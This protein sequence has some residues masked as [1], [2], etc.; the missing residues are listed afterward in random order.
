MRVPIDKVG[1]VGMIVDKQSY[2]LPPEAWSSLRNVRCID[3]ALWSTYGHAAIMGVPRVSPYFLLPTLD[4]SDSVLWAYLGT[5]KAW[6]T[7][8]TTHQDITRV[9]GGDYTG[10]NANLW[11]GGNF[12]GITIL[13]NGINNPQAWI[14]PALATPLVDL[15]NWPAST[16]ARVVR[17]LGRF[18]VALDVTQSSVRRSQLVKWSHEA[19]IG[20]VPS[21]WD[22]ADATKK[23]GEWPLLETEG[24]CIDL[25][26]LGGDGI[27]YKSDSIHRMSRIAGRFVFGFKQIF[28]DLGSGILA[29][30]CAAEWKGRHVVA[31]TEDVIV[32]DG[33]QYESLLDDSMYRWYQGRVDQANAFRSFVAVNGGEN[34][35][36]VCLPE[37][38]N[39]Y[40]NIALILNMKDGTKTIR[41]LPSVAHIHSGRPPGASQTFDA[42][43]IP[44]DSM[45][46]TFGQS[47][48]NAAR[49]RMVAAVPFAE[50]NQI[51][52]SEAL[53]TSW[54]LGNVTVQTDVEG[55]ADTIR[56]DATNNQ[57]FVSQLYAKLIAES[58]IWTLRAKMKADLYNF[59]VLFLDDNGGANRV[60]A[61][62]NVSTG[63]L[64]GTQV[65]GTGFALIAAAINGVADAQGYYD[66]Y[67]TGSTNA[68]A[69][70]RALIG[71]NATAVSALETFAGNATN[72]IRVKE[73]QF[74]RGALGT[75]QATTTVTATGAF[76]LMDSGLD[77]DGVA[78]TARAERLGLAVVGQ[79]RLG[80]PKSD[81]SVTKLITELYPKL[82]MLAGTSVEFYV[83]MQAVVGAGV[84]WQGPFSYTPGTQEKIDPML[85]GKL[86]AIA[87]QKIGT[88][89]FRLDGY[90]LEIAGI[91]SF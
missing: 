13:N 32:H 78:F 20:T 42:F 69:N 70:V 46:G 21:S 25:L 83:G 15:A 84:L 85:E 79:T 56:P 65:A 2:E 41:D 39:V 62:F 1:A 57:H 8:G 82:A 76:F 7:D 43:T 66:C 86:I 9:S 40:P 18:L 22:P 67:L 4:A 64:V 47:S 34:E 77:F 63:Q 58:Q 14:N 68:N 28:G 36:W 6:A 74:R 61:A 35:I 11:N 31:T 50:R 10:T 91:G 89:Q 81:I 48:T 26:P 71:V 60:L 12:G 30:R 54:T 55:T 16:T 19:D 3:G 90:D 27:I 17:P 51:L 52:Q 24:A 53:G 72:R 49:K 33:F 73:V 88:Q 44:F 59:G 37:S 5:A 29:Q 75:Y 80:E 38:G 87:I 23:A 45:I